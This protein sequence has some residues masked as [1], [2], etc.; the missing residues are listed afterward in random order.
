[1]GLWCKRCGSEEHVKN[2]LMRTKQALWNAIGQHLD[3]FTPEQCRNYLG[4]F[5]ICIDGLSF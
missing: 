1:M 4:G 2:G 3:D 5:E